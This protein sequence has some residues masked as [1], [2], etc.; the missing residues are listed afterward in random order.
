MPSFLSPSPPDQGEIKES[1]QAAETFSAACSRAA[2][3]CAGF[4]ASLERPWFNSPG[5][6]GKLDYH[7]REVVSSVAVFCHALPHRL[8][9][10][11]QRNRSRENDGSQALC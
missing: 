9:L 7:P 4:C 11:F 5:S 3:P 2:L 1:E 8:V 6:A 10:C